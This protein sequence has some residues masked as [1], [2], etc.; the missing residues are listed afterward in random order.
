VELDFLAMGIEGKKLLWAN[1]RDLA[2]LSSRLADIDF[3]G[4]IE[5]AQWQREEIEPFRA[6]AGRDALGSA[7]AG[8]AAP[9]ASPT[10]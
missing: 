7:G 4:L 1:L 10:L 5:R 8:R 6:Q 3:D 2:G 9:A